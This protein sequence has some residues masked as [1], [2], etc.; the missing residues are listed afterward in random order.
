MTE[1]AP[2]MENDIAHIYGERVRVRV[3]GICRQGESILMVN[4]RGITRTNFWSPPG[5]GVEFASTIDE[6]LTREFRE[7]TGLIIQPGKFLFG[8]E[9]IKDPLHAIELFFAVKPAGGTL[10]TGTDPELPIIE[11]VRFMTMSEIKNA[12]SDEVHGIFKLI[13]TLADLEE[14]AGFYRI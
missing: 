5:G 2:G 3:C 11:Q 10:M 12:G 7:E 8:C 1:I 9:F 13:N 6:T 4:H 14:L